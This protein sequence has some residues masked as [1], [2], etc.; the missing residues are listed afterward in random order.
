MTVTGNFTNI[1]EGE[2]LRILGE[3][4][5]HQT[6]GKQ[7]NS[8]K[9]LPH[10]TEE[11]IRKYLRSRKIRGLGPKTADNIVDRF[12][13]QTL[14]V[15]DKTPERLSEVA[16]IGSKK[17]DIILKS[18]EEHRTD[19]AIE[20]FLMSNGLS[21]S[22]SSRIQRFYG[23]KTFEIL[24]KNPYRLAMDIHGIGFTSADHFA[25][26]LGTQPDSH[27]R[28][29]AALI[30]VLS[31]SEDLGH[32]YMPDS[33]ILNATQEA[34]KLDI[35]ILEAHIPE[36]LLNL[37]REN[38]I[39]SLNSG[40]ESIHYLR[41]LFDAEQAVFRKINQ[42][43]STPLKADGQRIEEWL[44]YYK[45]N[46]A[47]NLS[48]TQTQAVRE[49]ATQRV[50]ILTGGPGVGKSTTANT[51]IKLIKGLGKEVV[52][53]AP[54]GRAAQRLTEISGES[55]QTLH[56]L[57]EWSSGGVFQKNEEQ[58]IAADAII[59]DEASMLDLRTASALL[60]AI[61][62]RSQIIF[63]G[64]VDQ[65]PSV[66]SGRILHDLIQS[67]RVP[68]VRLDQVFRQSATSYIIE[69]AHKMNQ[70]SIPTFC[71]IKE[72][73]CRFIEV[74]N[75]SDILDVVKKLI[76]IILPS[77]TS[78]HPIEDIQVLSPMK[79]TLLG[80]DQLNKELQAILNPFQKNQRE[81]KRQNFSLRPRDKVIQT[82]NNYELGVFNGDIG[83][84]QDAGVNEDQVFVKFGSKT[85]SYDR[86]QAK[87][88]RLAYAITIHKSQGSEFPVVVIPV[89]MQHYMMLQRNIFYTA[90][91]RAKK[92]A[93]F[94]GSSKAFEQAIQNNT[95]NF[96]RTQLANLLKESGQ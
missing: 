79:K 62:T 71:N 4:F 63:L 37:A 85:I 80:T 93:I 82:T 32:C 88:L 49:A 67:N 45:K 87:E 75:P 1:T 36:C 91:T 72:S 7:F 92:L 10:E 13:L 53:C 57:L 70:G 15:L 60:K 11:G 19:R 23:S 95:A 90:L 2:Y 33:E 61:D 74:D 55:A 46:L 56:R 35:T 65:L 34:T 54:T 21:P 28:I 41:D 17:L 58:P 78:H 77:K 81:F 40:S 3:Y 94:V 64:D 76:S 18:W 30:Y 50:F 8:H 84:V 31:K 5:E 66:G 83:Y 43:I 16:S 47:I 68:Y 14:D 48:E 52:L 73:D 89:T 27:E 86:E 44:S 6:Y 59:L 22:L 38:Y 26:S 42:L 24:T 12:G 69:S 96:R 51:M 25:L 39:V 20:M 9:K 29:Q